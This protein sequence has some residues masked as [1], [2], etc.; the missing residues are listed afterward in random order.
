MRVFG[1]SDNVSMEYF[2][3]EKIG[4]SMKALGSESLTRVLF[5]I[6]LKPQ[7]VDARVNTFAC[8]GI[9]GAN[10]PATLCVFHVFL[11]GRLPA[12]NLTVT[13]AFE[14]RDASHWDVLMDH[15]EASL[16]CCNGYLLCV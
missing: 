15:M 12:L 9:G 5:P 11:L 8:G 3:R 2:V 1:H 10:S 4:L 16:C 7:V 14:W 6:S 13:M